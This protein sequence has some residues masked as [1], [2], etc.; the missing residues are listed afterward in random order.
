MR[1]SE[2][3][4]PQDRQKEFQTEYPYLVVD[5]RYEKVRLDK[6]VMSQGTLIMP[7]IGETDSREI[8]SLDLPNSETEESW[9]R[10]FRDLRR[11]RL[12]G[13]L[14]VISDDHE[15]LHCAEDEILSR[16]SADRFSFSLSLLS[17]KKHQNYQFSGGGRRTDKRK[18]CSEDLSQRA[19]LHPSGVCPDA[20]GAK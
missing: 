3:P 1:K 10:T 8:L 12:E 19:I 6:K 2:L 7:R 11:R 18:K 17:Q 15:G 13:V 16:N 14:L 4:V 20:N 9:S 5:A